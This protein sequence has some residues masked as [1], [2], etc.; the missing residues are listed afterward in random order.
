MKNTIQNDQNKVFFLCSIGMYSGYQDL[1]GHLVTTTI[2]SGFSRIIFLSF[3][4]IKTTGGKVLKLSNFHLTVKQSV[5]NAS[6]LGNLEKYFLY[7]VLDFLA[8]LLNNWI[9]ST[10]R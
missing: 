4:R 5:S 10:A 7:F 2:P 1:F 8:K 9:K 3:S 6:F